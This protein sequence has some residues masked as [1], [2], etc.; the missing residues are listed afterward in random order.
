LNS[1]PALELIHSAVVSHRSHVG[2]LVAAFDHVPPPNPAPVVCPDD[3]GSE[4]VV[5]LAYP[6]HHAVRIDVDL[7]GCGGSDNGD[8]RGTGTGQAAHQVVRDLKRALEH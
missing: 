2:D 1:D 3:D 7:S 8:L 4:I 5:Y 6:K